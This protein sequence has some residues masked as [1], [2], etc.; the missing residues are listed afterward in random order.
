MLVEASPRLLVVEDDD[1]TQSNLRDIL[2]LDGYVVD[3]VATLEQARQKDWHEFFAFVLDHRLPDGT[4]EEL[5]PEI[6]D[7]A[8]SAGILIVTG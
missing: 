3:A 4:A 6:R 1:D 2:E 8:P 7:A 5:L